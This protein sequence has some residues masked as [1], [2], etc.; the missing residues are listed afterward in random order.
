MHICIRAVDASSARPSADF[1][2]YTSSER[3][4]KSAA[5]RDTPRRP[6][7]QENIRQSL[8]LVAVRQRRAEDM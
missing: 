2:R 1:Y 4:G 6:A 5:W 8:M 7:V 3:S